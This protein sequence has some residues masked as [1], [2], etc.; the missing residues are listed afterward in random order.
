MI[1]NFVVTS[2]KN[3]TKDIGIY[4]SLG[5][6]GFKISLIYIFQIILVSTISFIIS[7]VGAIIFLKLLDSSLSQEASHL[8]NSTYNLELAP[9]DFKT[10]GITGTGV[11]VAFA[12]AYIIPIISV[13]IPLLN[14]SRKK[15]IDVLKIS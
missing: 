13:I 3:S 4:M 8:I 5:M 2:I 6:N 10:F 7:S 15:P 9:I 12:I 11:G 14:L 1:F